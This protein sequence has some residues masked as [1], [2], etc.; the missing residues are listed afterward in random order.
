MQAKAH[1]PASASS[2]S[3][4][5][6]TPSSLVRGRLVRTVSRTGALLAEVID[7][8]LSS[9][10]ESVMEKLVRAQMKRRKA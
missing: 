10:D 5:P 7:A 3:A 4:I 8:A 9:L 2:V 6:Y 1:R